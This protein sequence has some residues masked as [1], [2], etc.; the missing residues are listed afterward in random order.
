MRIAALVSLL[1]CTLPGGSM[2]DKPRVNR[3]MIEAME[4]RSSV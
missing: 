4:P 1:L 3:G 2:A